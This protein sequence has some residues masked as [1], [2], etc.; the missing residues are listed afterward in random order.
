L[1]VIDAQAGTYTMIRGSI[2]VDAT[3]ETATASYSRTVVAADGTVVDQQAKAIHPPP[4]RTAG[5]RGDAAG[6]LPGLDAG[7]T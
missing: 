2:E 3:G 5:R 7:D 1:I 6:Q 4:G